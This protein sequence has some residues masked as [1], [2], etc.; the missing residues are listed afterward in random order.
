MGF[1]IGTAQLRFY[2]CDPDGG[3]LQG[4]R[5]NGVPAGRPT[6][7]NVINFIDGANIASTVAANASTRAVDVTIATTGVPTGSGAANTLAVWTAATVLSNFPPMLNGQLVIG[8]TGAAP[9]GATLT[10]ATN[11]AILN[12]PGAISIGLT[13]QVAI[14]NGGTG[15]A[16]ALAAFNALS[17]LTTQGDLLTRDATNNV[18]LAVGAANTLLRSNGTDPSWGTV[19]LLSAFHGDTT[20]GTV[21]RGD[22]V[23]GQGVVPTWTRLALGVAARLLR[24]DGTDAAWAQAVLTTDVTGILPIANGGT[25]ASSFGTPNGVVYF[26]ATRLVNDAD[27]TFDGTT[28]GLGVSPVAAQRLTIQATAAGFPTTLS[29]RAGGNTG[30]DG[31]VLDFTSLAGAVAARIFTDATG[32]TTR[33]KALQSLVLHYSD[34]GISGTNPGITITGTTGTV[35]AH[36]QL[37]VGT[38]TDAGQQGDLAAGLTG[39]A[40]KLFYDQ[41][42]GSLEVFNSTPAVAL[43]IYAATDELF[44]RDAAVAASASGRLRRNGVNLGWHDGTASRRLDRWEGPNNV[45]R[46]ERFI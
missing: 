7:G 16:T 35:T 22:L 33:V 11:I 9:V 13:G 44:F 8:S 34:I 29:L 39:A 41:S 26:D 43:G 20:A 31:A 38:V 1:Q 45:L 27:F 21:V 6:R 25:N 4:L 28:A 15:Q 23:T 19:N 2:H 37:N 5:L 40:F 32:G 3:I 30:G 24:S 10:A 12:T 18:R 36:Q 17:P 42:V 46:A 14:A